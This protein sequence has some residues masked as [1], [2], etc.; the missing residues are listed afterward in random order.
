MGPLEVCLI[1]LL[2]L[3]TS[4][5]Q[6]HKQSVTVH[7]YSRRAEFQE[8]LH[9]ENPQSLGRDK[10][11]RVYTTKSWAKVV[12]KSVCCFGGLGSLCLTNTVNRAVCPLST[13]LQLVLQCRGTDKKSFYLNMPILN[14]CIAK[15]APWV[16]D[17]INQQEVVSLHYKEVL[18]TDSTKPVTLAPFQ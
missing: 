17:L 14:V 16:K 12:L 1:C 2:P 8:N 10:L 13:H 9:W 6:D 3:K 5:I 11:Q 4:W 15:V 7:L 18:K